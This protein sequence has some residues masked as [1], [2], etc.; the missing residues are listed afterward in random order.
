MKFSIV[1]PNWN[2]LKYLPLCLKSLEDQIRK[3][4]QIIVV[5]NGSTDG[6]I[7]Y[8]LQNPKIELVRLGKNFGFPGGVNAGIKEAKG[9]LI[10]LLNN[11]T[12]VD[13][14]WVETMVK[15]ATGNP[16]ADFFAS[17]M[18]D[19][20]KREIVDCCGNGMSWYGRS[21]PRSRGEKSR[22]HNKNE[23]V[24]GACAGA[25]VYRKTLFQK[26]GYFD[27]DFFF[28]LEDVDMDFR[29]ELSGSRCLFVA[30][31][32][33]YHLGSATAG[34]RSPFSFKMMVKN[35]FHL[36]YKNIP[37]AKFWLNL[38]KIFYSEARF[39]LASIRHHFF[40]EYF[41]GTL[42]A[43]GQYRLMRKKRRLI[44]ST[45]KVDFAYLNSIIDRNFPK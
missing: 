5:D 14:H 22:D 37:T 17:K 43:M 38:H 9:E 18:L 10:A 19:F 2:G 32:I 42:D 12:E 29:S 7:E 1:I 27:E 28:S 24:F 16:E 26:V 15:A 31:A 39:F 44:Q 30:D 35:H 23:Y 20:E 11:D 34:A 6:S 40:K 4:D 33:V 13:P 21:Y 8:L 45:R 25:A 41:I 3:A 36:M